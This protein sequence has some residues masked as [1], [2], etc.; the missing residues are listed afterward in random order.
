MT[1]IEAWDKA[2]AG[3]WIV[4][5]TAFHVIRIKKLTALPIPEWIPW[6]LYEGWEV[7]QYLRRGKK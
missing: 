5:Q 7:S 6:G 1:L 4:N 2:E 3:Q